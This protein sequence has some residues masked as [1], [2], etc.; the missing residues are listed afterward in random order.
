VRING[1]LALVVA[2]NEVKGNGLQHEEGD[3]PTVSD[4]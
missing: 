4:E 3:E 2:N 1:T